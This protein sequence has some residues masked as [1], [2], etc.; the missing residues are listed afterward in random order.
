MSPSLLATSPRSHAT[1]R[2]TPTR[3]PQQREAKRLVPVTESP[4]VTVTLQITLP[5]QSGDHGEAVNT[6]ARLAER[7]HAIASTAAT[8]AASGADVST[9][10][11]VLADS[12]GR[13]HQD[14][15]LRPP[16]ARVVELVNEPAALRILTERREA[17]LAG[18]PLVLTRREYDLLL[19]LASHPGR[20]FT[21]P[22]LLKWVWG[23]SIISGERTV[24][25]HVRRLRT[26]LVDLGP[27]ITTVRGIG[28]RLDDVDR[29]AVVT[30][31]PAVEQ[32]GSGVQAA[33][34]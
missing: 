12:H 21:R 2:P 16:S 11:A 10:V 20:V 13:L 7:L 9:T 5:G 22:Q 25:V 24:D 8:D 29:V 3:P 6:A 15:A 31:R 34:D 30:H 17:L 33:V 18:T 23:H 14:S 1:T 27:T 32:P 4:A 19:F 28:Y 26:K